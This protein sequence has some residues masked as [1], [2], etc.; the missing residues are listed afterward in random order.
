[1]S[2]RI[3]PKFGFIATL[4]AVAVT[5]VAA[6]LMWQSRDTTVYSGRF[7][8]E[9][10][11]K[12]RPGMNLQEVYSLLGQPL[13][14]RPENSPERWCYCDAEVLRKDGG[15]VVEN[16]LSPSPCVLFDEKGKVLR[17]NGAKVAPVTK[18]MTAKEVLRLLGQPK[19]RKPASVMT[20]HYTAPGGEGLF[21]ARIVA[22]DSHNRVSDVISYQFYD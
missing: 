15:L 9:I 10:F 7:S 4:A 13:G 14:V 16:F 12:V 6:L 21:R 19:S 20:L 18:G 22:V 11:R 1:M 3:G 17:V 2:L 8:E 5:M